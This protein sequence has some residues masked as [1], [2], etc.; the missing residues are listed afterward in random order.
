[1]RASSGGNG[2]RRAAVVTALVGAI[3]LVWYLRSGGGGD[4][5]ASPAPATSSAGSVALPDGGVASAPPRRPTNTPIGL[6]PGAN[7]EKIREALAQYLIYAEFPPW[8]RPADGSQ[9]HLWKWN[10]PEPAGQ[11]F[12]NDPKRKKK[13]S[14][15]LA[16]DKMFAGPGETITATLTVWRGDYADTT[17]EPADAKVVGYIEAYRS[18]EPSPSPSGKPPPS[19]K[20]WNPAPGAEGYFPVEAVTFASVAGGPG[21]RYVAKFTPSTIAALKKQVEA[22]FVA[23]ADADGHAF[24]FIQQFRYASVAPLVVLDKHTDALVKGSLEVTLGVD[25]KHLG[26]VLVQATLYDAAGTMPIAIYDG[27]YRPAQLGPQELKITFFGKAIHDKGV[28]GPYSVHAL[29][30]FVRIDDGEPP[31]LFWESKLPIMT[32][33]YAATDFAAGEWDSA[34]KQDKIN[35]YKQMIGPS[36]NK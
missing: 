1:M 14:A 13:I 2:T 3:A 29:H 10:Q 35:Q 23:S 32:N 25:I 7:P 21:H 34:E 18:A 19:P 6:P 9:E 5:T 33:T 17:K 26:P 12:A 11:A 16:L 30:G 20:T 24:P 8:S 28:N 15:E 36:G 4:R 22:R 27:Y 31:E